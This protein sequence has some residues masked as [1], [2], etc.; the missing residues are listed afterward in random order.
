MA[1]PTAT[2]THLPTGRTWTVPAF[3]SKPNNR[4]RVALRAASV[5]DRGGML[6]CAAC[7][8]L[9][10]A[11]G[12][13]TL[14]TDLGPVSVAVGEAD[15]V[16]NDHPAFRVSAPVAYA[17]QTVANVCAACNGSDARAAHLDTLERVA[18]RLLG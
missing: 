10:A 16:V 12:V 4:R 11:T 9:T 14:A 2:V 3:T 5:G 13:H 18:L 7:G 15:R 1:T 6:P 8:A 17:A